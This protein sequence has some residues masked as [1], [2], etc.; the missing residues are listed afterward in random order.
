MR[1]VQLRAFHHVAISGGF[2]N[3][4][5][6]LNLTQP[7]V[8]D[9]V[10]RLE[11]DYDVLLFD[12]R[13]KLVALTEAGEKLLEIT[14]RLFEAERQASDLLSETR[15]L[16]SGQLRIYAD[17]ALHLSAPLAAF[18]NRFPGVQITVSA[19]NSDAVTQA[20]KVYEADIGVVGEPPAER[21]FEQVSLGVSPIVACVHRGSELADRS[22]LTLADLTEHPLVL[23]EPGSK[24]RTK[25]TDAAAGSGISLSPAIEAEGREAVREIVASGAGI[26]FVSEAEFGR[27]DRLV[28]IPISAPHPL[29]MEEFALCLS[30]RRHGRVIGAF[31]DLVRDHARA[32]QRA[33]KT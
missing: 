12:R 27:D 33:D 15:A 21:G 8:S 31:F 14:R 25:L 9:Q 10:R 6:V 29:E 20:L 32:V 3:A 5:A 22:V 17:A 11:E 7:A 30:N 28:A 16:R 24:T 2:S 1:Y 18:R 26:G 19:G 4:A 23:R 13:R